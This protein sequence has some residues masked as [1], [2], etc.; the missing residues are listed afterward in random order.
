VTEHGPQVSRIFLRGEGHDLDLGLHF[1]EAVSQ[2]HPR[3]ARKTKFR[4]HYVR[5]LFVNNIEHFGS[6]PAFADDAQVRLAIV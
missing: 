6:R 5:F 4:Q 2:F 3:A 1:L